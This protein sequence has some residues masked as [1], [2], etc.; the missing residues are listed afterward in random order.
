MPVPA[1]NDGTLA[2]YT[3]GFAYS[4]QTNFSTT[5]KFDDAAQRKGRGIEQEPFMVP[6]RM[7]NFVGKPRATLQ[8]LWTL[9][10]Q[11]IGH[12]QNVDSAAFIRH[13]KLLH[14]A[15]WVFLRAEEESKGRGTGSV[16]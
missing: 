14:L 11:K 10:I 12:A 13:R 15:S 7:P 2:A 16:S 8:H 6:K 5:R 1:P 4:D 9:L 3:N